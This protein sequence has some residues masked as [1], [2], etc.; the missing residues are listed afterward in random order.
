MH[1]PLRFIGQVVEGTVSR[2]SDRWFLSVTVEIPD[3]PSV[4]RES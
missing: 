3:P 1:E 2:V 4:R